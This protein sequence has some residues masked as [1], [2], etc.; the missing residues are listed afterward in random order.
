MKS[1][2]NR[3][4]ISEISSIERKTDYVSDISQTIA[5]INRNEYL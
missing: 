5:I 3:T 4:E 2:A 1:F